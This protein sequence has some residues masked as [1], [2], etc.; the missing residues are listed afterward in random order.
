MRKFFHNNRGEFNQRLGRGHL[1]SDETRLFRFDVIIIVRFGRDG[2]DGVHSRR[3]RARGSSLLGIIFHRKLDRDFRVF[4]RLVLRRDFRLGGG[5][6]FD[7]FLGEKSL[8][9]SA[10]W[11]F[12]VPFRGRCRRRIGRRGAD[13]TGVELLGS[14]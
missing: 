1:K 13:S 3:Y 9:V 8:D 6:G 2:D 14:P 5:G 7:G 11:S 10:G 12:F 4:R